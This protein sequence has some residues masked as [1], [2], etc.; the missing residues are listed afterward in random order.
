MGDDK[1]CIGGGG[2]LGADDALQQGLLTGIDGELQL[3]RGGVVE[4]IPRTEQQLM[5][6]IAECGQG[7]AH[8]TG[9]IVAKVIL[10]RIVEVVGHVHIAVNDEFEV[11]ANTTTCH[12]DTILVGE[13]SIEIGSG[14]DGAAIHEVLAVQIAIDRR[15][16]AIVGCIDRA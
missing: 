9:A 2:V 6:A 10:E 16:D 12:V 14:I 11:M 7:V 13:L 3:G 8:M 1:L 5:G 4:H 15:T